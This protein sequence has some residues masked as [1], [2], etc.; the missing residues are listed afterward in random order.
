MQNYVTAGISLPKDILLE[1]D[2]E[3]GDIPRNKYILRILQ[4]MFANAGTPVNHKVSGKDSRDQ[5]LDPKDHS[6]ESKDQYEPGVV[7]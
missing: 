3:R 4:R 2:T 1:I 7:R 5:E 6:G